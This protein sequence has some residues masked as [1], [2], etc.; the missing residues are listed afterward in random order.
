MNVHEKAEV[1]SRFPGLIITRQKRSA[2]IAFY[3]GKSTFGPLRARSGIYG[4]FGPYK[5]RIRI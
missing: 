4:T 3:G 5:P 1:H 2:M